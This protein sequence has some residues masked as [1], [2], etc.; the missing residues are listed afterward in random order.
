MPIRR[1]VLSTHTI[2]HPNPYVPHLDLNSVLKSLPLLLLSGIGLCAHDA[3]TPV[4]PVLLVLVGV[5]LLDRRHE[6]G[7]LGLVLRL[8]LCQSKDG[9]GLLVD[10]GA[11]AGLAL[12]YGVWDA[13]LAAKSWEEDNKLD[14][15]NVVGDEDEGGLLVLDEAD[16]VV[17]A[18]LDSVWFLTDVLALLAILDGGG[19]LLQTLL[20]LSLGLWSVLVQELEHLSGLVAVEAGKYVRNVWE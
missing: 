17:E 15:I 3:T 14:W 16:D 10:Y 5:T 6:L 11:E 18:V 4:S 12:D 8:D 7:E 19:L 9:G 2:T 13:H 20:F 1:L